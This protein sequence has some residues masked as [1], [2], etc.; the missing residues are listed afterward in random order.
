MVFVLLCFCSFSLH[1]EVYTFNIYREIKH[2][3]NALPSGL[4]LSAKVQ[5]CNRTDTL[6]S[7]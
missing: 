6:S 3:T 7:L 5:F 4:Y 2:R 1:P